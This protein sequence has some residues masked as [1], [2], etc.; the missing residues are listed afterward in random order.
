M[1]RAVTLFSVFL[2]SH[3][4][5]ICAALRAFGRGIEGVDLDIVKEARGILDASPVQYVKNARM[6]GSLFQ[7]GSSD[8]SV[9]CAGT[10]FCVDQAEPLAALAAIKERGIEWPFG[11]LPEDCEFLTL[12]GTEGKSG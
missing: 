12:I 8:G 4:A 6:K 9:C 11:D 3:P 7:K 1:I 2:S 5:A 10:S